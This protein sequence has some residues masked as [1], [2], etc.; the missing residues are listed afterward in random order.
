M[1][2]KNL[3]KFRKTSVMTRIELK[4]INQCYFLF[5]LYELS[6]VP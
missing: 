1:I 6:L 2:M 4:K 5:V 3:N